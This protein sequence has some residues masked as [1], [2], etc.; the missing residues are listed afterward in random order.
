MP[1]ALQQGA[2]LAH[3]LSSGKKKKKNDRWY[4]L[5]PSGAQGRVSVSWAKTN[6]GS[7]K[8]ETLLA[9]HAE[10]KTPTPTAKHACLTTPILTLTR[11]TRAYINVHSW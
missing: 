4:W 2:K 3:C 1:A 7:G 8:E 10:P 5:T 6:K 9:V 11:L